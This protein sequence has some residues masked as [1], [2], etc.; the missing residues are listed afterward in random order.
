MAGI[1][2]SK[3]SALNDS[4][5]GKSEAP[6]RAFLEKAV[7]AYEDESTINKIFKMVDSEHYAEK[8][9][10]IT[11]F[12]SGF[13]PVGEGSPYPT[14]ERQEGYSKT[15]ENITWKDSFSITQEMIEDS[16]ILD[17]SRTGA[18]AFIDQY[19]LTREK[20]G[21]QLLIGAVSGTSTSF[22]GLTMNCTS[23]DGVSLFSTAHTSK[24][25]NTDT[26]SNKFEGALSADVIGQIETKMQNFTD[27]NGELLNIA[28]DTI[29]I[30][31]DHT[32]K[33]TLFAAIGADKDPDTANNGYNYQFGRWTVI[34]SPYLNALIGETDK[35]FF[36]LD[37]KYNENYD[38]LLF[39]DRIPLTIKSYIDDETDNNVWAGRSRFVCGANNWRAI[40]AGGVT[41][42]TAL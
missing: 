3:G 25:G 33:K 18:R 20:Y 8:F 30:P 14:D 31:N 38:G 27:D 29:I 4:I 24:T 41:G 7:Y 13:Q 23:A 36:M 37:S 42:A 11:G 17:L 2:F 6:I 1:V 12:A 39:L 10:G 26:Q 32:L 22:R 19:H 35:P 21:S 9:G 28:P 40:A 15:L 16:V 5:Y 34:V